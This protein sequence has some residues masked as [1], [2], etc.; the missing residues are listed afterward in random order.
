MPSAVFSHYVF[1]DFE[2]ISELDLKL[3]EGRPVHVTLM[4]GKS[5]TRLAVGLVEDLH[6][7]GAQVALV[8]L[9]GS[10]RNALD[11][12]LS[13]YLGKAVQ[14]FPEAQFSILSGDKDFDPLVEHLMLAGVKV[15][16]TERFKDLPF[17]PRSRKS[18]KK[19]V[20]SAAQK[21]SNIVVQSADEAV[22]KTG[23]DEAARM[24]KL[25]NR[26]VGKLGPRPRNLARLLAYVGTGFGGK[27]TESEQLAKVEELKRRG[28]LSI[29]GKGRVLYS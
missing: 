23:L 19:T 27:L 9:A 2:N 5:H 17:F 26:L 20:V 11:L 3:L 13:C 21:V 7:A 24:E 18:A 29:D 15:Q 14:Q 1:V 6:R 8:R 4:L 28:V 22:T 10:G 25:C 12:T 16:R